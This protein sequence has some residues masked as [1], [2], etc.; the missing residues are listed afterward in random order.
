FFDQLTTKIRNACQIHSQRKFSIRGR[1]TVLK[2]LVLSRLWH[3]LRLFSITKAQCNAIK[4]II[5]KFVNQ[6]CF[7]KLSF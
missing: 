7:P 2:S 1:A 3:V 5:S 6:S 4:S